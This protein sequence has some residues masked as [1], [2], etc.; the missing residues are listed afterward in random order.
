VNRGRFRRTRAAGFPDICLQ[1]LLAL[2]TMLAPRAQ[3][4][5]LPPGFQETRVAA[6]LSS[7]T[8]MAFAPDG[9]LFICQQGGQLRVFKNG[10]LLPTPFVSLNVD[11]SGE[12][13]L[14]GVAFDP[15]F[16]VNQWV[17]VY[18]TVNT[19]PRRNRISRFTANGDVALNG[20]ELV[21]LELDDLNAFLN[22]NGGAIHFGPDGKL[23][24]AVGENNVPSNSQSLSN[25]LGKILRINSD[26]SIPTDN[27][28]YLTATGVNRA[29][30]AL[31]LRNPFTFA[32]DPAS[33]R[34]LINDVGQSSWEEVNDG[35]AGSN[36]GW[37][38]TEG[39]TPD[40]QYRSPIHAY[41]HGTSL[42]QGCAI[43]GAA[44]YSPL[45]S[46]YPAAYLGR[47]FFADLCSGWI[48]SLDPA[49]AATSIFAVGISFPV[50]IQLG[51]DGFLY[52]LARGSGSVHR[53]SYAA[54]F[55]TPTAAMR[56][57][58]GGIQLDAYASTMLRGA[59][60]AF[61]SPPAVAHNP[62]GDTFAVARDNFGSIWASVFD[63]TTQTW[64]AWTFGGGVIRGT[65]AIAVA[66]A[67]TAYIGVRDTFDSYWLVRFTR[68]SGFSGW[69]Y[70]AGIFSTDP[71]VGISPAG[72]LY[73]VGKDNFG[74]L[75]SARYLSGSGFQGWRYGAGIVRG[76]PSLAVGTDGVA[77]V[78][79][80]DTFDA[81][82]M[83][84][85]QNDT[86]LGWTWGGGVLGSDPQAA[87]AGDGTIQVAL[88]DP[89][90]VV[91]RRSYLEGSAT[92]WQAWSQI[93]GVLS[94]FAIASSGGELY[95]A[96]KD[97]ANSLW[98]YRSG[99]NAWVSL[100]NK[101]GGELSAAPR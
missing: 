4:A 81:I 92:G 46:Q 2:V 93:N 24:A 73:I 61:A 23:Y 98:W 64:D 19:T 45:V 40:P 57:A 43:T 58:G 54:G 80:R 62:S 10:A 85:V 91:W 96:G 30:W 31:G 59:G 48:R 55:R 1:G 5:G 89:G 56:D 34:M 8:A 35:I 84:R 87:A 42:T 97:A 22:H 15:N 49:T 71:A 37:P 14:L 53:V 9:R 39:P 50:D 26:G 18:Y 44:F 27:P 88:L 20:S 65:P 32:F 13:G 70:L 6:G 95:L 52:Y 94:S 66:D 7:P 60:G 11:S 38:A 28:W 99:I 41:G 47:Y 86:W 16:A 90:N 74:S 78:A 77:Y 76:K 33:G 69:T 72:T 12:R 100:G 17:Y 79:V 21:I 101:G 25:L 36:Y 51:T 75:W 63:A 29:I 67:T 68:G 83:A 3:A 82:W